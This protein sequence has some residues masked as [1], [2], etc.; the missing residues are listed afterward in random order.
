MCPAVN[1]GICSICRWQICL[2]CLDH[3]G[4][5]AAGVTAHAVRRSSRCGQAA[6]NNEDARDPLPCVSITGRLLRRKKNNEM[7][8]YGLT[9]ESSNL[10]Q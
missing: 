10:E 6:R 8:D 4:A 9:M 5:N 3:F 1:T 7:H 2:K